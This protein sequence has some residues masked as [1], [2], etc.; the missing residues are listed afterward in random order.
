[1]LK[2]L[3]ADQRETARRATKSYLSQYRSEWEVIGEA[4]NSDGLLSKLTG[5]QPDVVILSGS[6]PGSPI[7]SLVSTLKAEYPGPSILVLGPNREAALA[8]GADA[9]VHQGDSPERLLTA[10]RVIQCEREDE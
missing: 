2:I 10:L 4:E 3:L 9:F 1:M 7:L 6:L 8:V 5:L